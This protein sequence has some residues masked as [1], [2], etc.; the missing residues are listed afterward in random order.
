VT[1]EGIAGVGIHSGRPVRVRLH[2]APGPLRFRTPGG[3]VPAR[4]DAVVATD[5][6]TVL[7]AGAARVAT[8]EHV[9]AALR[10]AGF[11]SGVVVELDAEELPILDGSAR[12][13][14][15]A[16]DALGAPPPAPAPL[17]VDRP[18]AWREGASEVRLVPGAAH[19]EV[20]IDFPAPIG[21]QGWSGSPERFADVLSARTFAFAD[22]LAALR[23]R[24]LVRGASEG[25][26]ILF[27]HEGPHV[28]LRSADEP[29]RHKALDA[30][31]DLALIGRPI[32][33]AVL[34]RHGSHR[35]HVAAMQQL[36]ATLPPDAAGHP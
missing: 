22:D 31:G 3:E 4:V 2:R 26:G 6:S 34:V 36:L 19:L 11:W 18:W 29:A 13:W 23:A 17:V 25:S 28:P 10:V 8:V 30:L 16:I 5:R 33:A 14:C 27:T 35:A 21:T 15:A 24:G 32:A 9:L 7:G 20:A 1:D 12:A